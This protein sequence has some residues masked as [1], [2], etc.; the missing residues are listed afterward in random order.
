MI[1][2]QLAEGAQMKIEGDAVKANRVKQQA[3]DDSELNTGKM[4]PEKWRTNRKL[5]Q[6]GLRAEQDMIYAGIED[7]PARDAVDSYYKAI[8]DASSPN[9]VDVDWEK[10]DIWLAN[11]SPA[12]QALIAKYTGLGGT[13]TEKEYKAAVKRI[14]ATDYWNV[15][16]DLARDIT[17]PK[18]AEAGIILPP[19]LDTRSEIEGWLVQDI[20]TEI[21]KDGIDP[22]SAEGIALTGQILD[23]IFK[24]PDDLTA[25]IRKGM[26]EQIPGLMEDLIEW[27]YYT[28]GKEVTG[29]LLENAAEEAT[30]E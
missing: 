2:E 1:V 5:R 14:D 6:A 19:G 21:R 12:D 10:V 11:Q 15:V 18:L 3:I 20:A 26:R 4:D 16:D 17:L 24:E 27:G 7:K 29:Q 25:Q 30:D 23:A 13:K 22:R 28:P 9:G 8:E